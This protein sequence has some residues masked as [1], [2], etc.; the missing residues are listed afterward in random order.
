MVQLMFF[1]AQQTHAYKEY[2]WRYPGNATITKH[3][4]LKE[5]KAE[6]TR[7]KEDMKIYIFYARDQPWLFMH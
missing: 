2:K 1:H 6:V 4:L 3:N 5:P 7:N